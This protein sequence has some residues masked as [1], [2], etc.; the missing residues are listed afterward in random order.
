MTASSQ[1]RRVALFRGL[2]QVWC[3]GVTV[4]IT[5]CCAQ[6]IV[7]CPFGR[8]DTVLLWLAYSFLFFS[9]PLMLSAAR[10]ICSAMSAYAWSMM[11]QVIQSVLLRRNVQKP[12]FLFLSD[13][14]ATSQ[15]AARVTSIAG[16]WMCLSAS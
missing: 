15:E 13:V 11:P 2:A 10:P 3:Q 6:S 5:L 7:A 16:H 4:D 14:D 8:K 9:T 1:H 12:H